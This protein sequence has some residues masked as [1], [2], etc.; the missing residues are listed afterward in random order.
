[1]PMKVSFENLADESILEGLRLR[2]HQ[3]VEQD[4]FGSVVVGVERRED[5]RIYANTDFRKAGAV[6]GF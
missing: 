2:G 4:G 3:L 6:D 1:M 5:G